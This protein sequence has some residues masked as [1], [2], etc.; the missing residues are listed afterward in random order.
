[1]CCRIWFSS[2][3]LRMLAFILIRMLAYSFLVVSLTGFGIRAISPCRM[4]LAVF[5]S[6]FWENFEKNGYQFFFECL[7]EFTWSHFILAFLCQKVFDY[8]F[9]P[10]T[11]YQSVQIF[12]FL[13]N[14][15]LVSCTCLG[16]SSFLIVCSVYWY[17]VVHSSLLRSSISVVSA[18]M[19][20]IYNSE[21]SFYFLFW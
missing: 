15:N 8:W 6:V 11:F 4:N 13:H 14:S 3:F 2:I 5:S 1:M 21:S 20:L 9:K 17:I 16:I 10:L 7:V 12:L 18:V 19:F